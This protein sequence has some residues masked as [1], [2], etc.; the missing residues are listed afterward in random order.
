MGNISTQC[1]AKVFPPCD[2]FHIVFP[3]STKKAQLQI[4]VNFIIKTKGYTHGY[5]GYWLLQITTSQFV[6]RTLFVMYP[7]N[8]DFWKNKCCGQMRPNMEAAPC[9]WCYFQY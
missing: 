6:D 1:L 3:G 5:S 7:T 2:L 9:Y 4:F 8:P